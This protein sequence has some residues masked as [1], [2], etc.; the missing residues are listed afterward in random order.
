MARKRRSVNQERDPR[1]DQFKQDIS[2]DADV[3]CDQRDAANSDMRFINVLDGMWENFLEDQYACDNE[4]RVRLQM[5]LVSGPRN[6]F[7]GEWNQ[8]RVGVEYK[9]D[10]AGTTKDDSNLLNGIYRSDFRQFSGK[11]ATDNAVDEVATC[12]IGHMKLATVFEDEEDPENENMNIEWRPIYS[13]YST[14][15]WDQAS[16]RIDKRDARYCT[17][18]TPYTNASFAREWPGKTPSSAYTPEEYD[19]SHSGSRN[20]RTNDD[21]IYVGTRY[22]VITRKVKMF[23]YN[24]LEA[25]KVSAYTEEDHELIK[26]ELAKNELVE[27]VR[28]RM[29]TRQMVE[30]TV[31]SGQDILEETRRVAGKW[32]P[33]VPF[34]GYRAFVDGVEWY[35]GLIRKLKD[36]Q[37]LFNT[38]ISQLAENAAS[39]GQEVPIFA[40]EQMQN[41]DIQDQWADKNNKPYLLAEPLRDEANNIVS[42]GPLGYSKPAQLDASTSALVQLIPQM[43]QEITGGA[44]EDA[45]SNDMS[46]KAINALIKR[47][48][49]VSQVINDNIAN[50]IA[51]SGEVYKAMAAEVYTTSRIVK[52]ISKD[53]SEGTEQLLGVVADDQTGKLIEGNDLRGKKFQSYADVGPQYDT[54]REQ[55]VEEIK[56]MM[57]AM[58]DT[59]EAA[60]YRPLLISIMI[61]NISG[62]GLEPLKEFNRKQMLLQGLVKP[63]NPEEE[64]MLQ[65]AQQPKEDPQ[66]KLMEA[67]TQ[68]QE[69]EARSLDASSLQKTADASKKQA[70]TAEILAGIDRDDLQL[71]LD[72][73]NTVREDAQRGLENARTDLV[74]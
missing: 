69:A 6:R 55:T 20:G 3:T 26:D 53:G 17:E 70:E 13:S 36:G 47:Q 60:Q 35:H 64:A 59:P 5:D 46:G 1:L 74:Q 31:F 73:Q 16:L 48:N 65:A 43:M 57:E 39:A 30:K 40:P 54:V 34:Y 12:G 11:L 10:D 67:A 29:V 19:Y 71:F 21:F 66:K 52:T 58:G 68:Q 18:L 72:Q 37:R 32:I 38:Q 50:A 44:P 22:E 24:D 41:K 33:I 62:V 63:E 49:M 8:N 9:P 51:W 4:E 28:E 61:N 15:Y 2:D 14:V 42:A 27:F 7:V 23:V 25:E 45:R 56:G